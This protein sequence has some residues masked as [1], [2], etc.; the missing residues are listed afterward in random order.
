L[1]D[2]DWSPGAQDVKLSTWNFCGAAVAHQPDNLLWHDFSF[3]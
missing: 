1:R 3:N 2:D